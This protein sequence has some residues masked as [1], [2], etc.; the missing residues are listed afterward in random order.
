MAKNVPKEI[1]ESSKYQEYMRLA[2]RADQRMLRLE[3]LSNEKYYEGVLTYA[4]KYAERSII[5]LGG[6]SRFRS[7]KIETED[8]LRQAMAGV[9]YFL[10]APSSTKQSIKKVYQKRAKTINEKFGTNLTWQ[11]MANVWEYIDSQ[12][13]GRVNYRSIFRTYD[14]LKKQEDPE[15]VL[16]DILEGNKKNVKGD[17]SNMALKLMKKYGKDIVKLLI[18]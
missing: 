6:G 2:H 14:N 12:K 11:E 17:L 9:K 13:G 5:E 18:K 1:R 8:D 10:G 16:Q 7:V 15:R 4:Y 3:R